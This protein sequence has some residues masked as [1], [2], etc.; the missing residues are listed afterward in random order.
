MKVDNRKP[1]RALTNVANKTIRYVQ[2]VFSDSIIVVIDLHPADQ[3][4]HQL[5]HSVR[6]QPANLQ[7]ALMVHTVCVLITLHHLSQINQSISQ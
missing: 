6:A 4:S 5:L 2:R 3:F 7:D 1:E